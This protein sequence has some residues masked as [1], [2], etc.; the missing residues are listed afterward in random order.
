VLN[1]GF[2]FLIA[3]SESLFDEWWFFQFIDQGNRI[4]VIT[5][6]AVSLFIKKTGLCLPR[7]TDG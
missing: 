5:D 2:N 1:A 3:D 7:M 6:G 4:I